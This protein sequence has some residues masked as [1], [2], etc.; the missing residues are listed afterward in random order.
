MSDSVNIDTSKLTLSMMF[1]FLKW[2]MCWGLQA[3]YCFVVDM[4]SGHRNKHGID[5]QVSER[6]LVL[7]EGTWLNLYTVSK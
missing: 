3:F 1:Y 2:L 7:F 6:T 4:A 5:S